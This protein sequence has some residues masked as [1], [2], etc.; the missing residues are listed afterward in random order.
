MFFLQWAGQVQ[1]VREDVIL[2]RHDLQNVLESTYNLKTKC[3][4]WRTQLF[5]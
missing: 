5:L 3:L 1:W 2:L 4:T